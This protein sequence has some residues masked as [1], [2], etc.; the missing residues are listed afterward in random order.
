MSTPQ[1]KRLPE[2]ELDVMLVLWQH[3]QP[4]RTAQILQEIQPYHSWTISTLKALLARLEEKQFVRVVR[5]GR[6]ALYQALVQE[7]DYCRQETKGLMQR[8]YKNS[9][10]NMVAALV[11][12]HQLS[13]QELA[14]L[15]EIIHSAGKR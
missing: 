4:V 12:D 13:G 9:V 15:E 11:Q 14:E 2:S 8:Y 10:K 1:E 7:K 3:S 5:Q 6:F